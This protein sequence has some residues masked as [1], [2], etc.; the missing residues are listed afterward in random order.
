MLQSGV[1]QPSFSPVLTCSHG[2]EKGW[3][4]EVL[5]GLLEA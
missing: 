4:L 3:I 2:E 5:R 1:I